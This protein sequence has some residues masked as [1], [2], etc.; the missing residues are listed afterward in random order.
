MS[1][2]ILVLALL[3]L[4][5]PS[6]HAEELTAEQRHAI[7]MAYLEGNPTGLRALLPSGRNADDWF[8]M[9]L[10]EHWWRPPTVA[11]PPEPSTLPEQEIWPDSADRK[12]SALT[13]RRIDWIA[14]PGPKAAYPMPQAGE[15]D[16]WPVLTAL[17]QDRLLREQGGLAAVRAADPLGKLAERFRQAQAAGTLSKHREHQLWWIDQA[18][19]DFSY[20]YD[21]DPLTPDQVASKE[22]GEAIARRNLILALISLLLLIAVPILIGRRAAASSDES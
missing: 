6:A 22:E 13:R 17:V 3:C 19:N 7:V 9:I 11:E 15:T 21:G 2:L 12:A 16:P 18:R 14:A 5:V 8:P 10:F 4:V 20:G 1:R